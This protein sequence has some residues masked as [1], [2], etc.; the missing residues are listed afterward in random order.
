M[1]DTTWNQ[2]YGDKMGTDPNNVAVP[3]TAQ[4]HLQLNFT[5]GGHTT[6]QLG[7]VP[8]DYADKTIGVSKFDV[9][10]GS[11][12]LVYTCDTL[13]GQSFAG[14]L[15]NPGNGVWSTDNIKL[16]AEYK[17]GNWSATYT[18]AA[19][20]TSDWMLLVQGGGNKTV[21]LVE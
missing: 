12:D 18:A 13:P 9:D 8:K 5:K 17:G 15:P 1:D 2:T 14:Y 7:Y 11:T 10:I 3:M 4:D 19:T 6:F 20:D 21:R 16:P